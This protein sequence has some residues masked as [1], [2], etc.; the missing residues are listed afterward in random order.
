MKQIVLIA[1]AISSPAVASSPAAWA[2]LDSKSVA[3][4]TK[5][6]AIDDALVGPA[7]RFSDS[8][9]ID[10]REVSGVYRQKRMLGAKARML[11]LIQRKTGRVEI[12]EK[13]AR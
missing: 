12:Q 5:A 2:A 3:A 11:C 7:V 4:C 10:V 6:A 13:P 1:L 9:G 8:F